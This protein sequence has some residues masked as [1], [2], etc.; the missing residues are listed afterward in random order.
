MGALVERGVIGDFRPPDILR[1]GLTPLTL[2]YADRTGQPST[3]VVSPLGLAQKGTVWYLVANTDAGRRTFR[4]GRVTAVQPLDTPRCSTS[5]ASVSGAAPTRP[6]VCDAHRR[7]VRQN[8]ST[9]IRDGFPAAGSILVP[10]IA[11]QTFLL[12]QETLPTSN[13]SVARSGVARGSG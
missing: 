9:G 4:V 5:R 11:G 2:R 8:R 6:F 1:F 10:E 7:G 12:N 3:R 13:R